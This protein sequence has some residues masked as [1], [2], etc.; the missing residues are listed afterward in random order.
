MIGAEA[1]QCPCAANAV[2]RGIEPKR[3]QQSRRRRR[4]AG[5][6]LPRLD[7]VL[8]F[9]QVEPLDIGPDHSCRMILP[10]QAIDIDGSQFDLVTHRLTQPRRSARHGLSCWRRLFRKFIKKLVVSHH[11]LRQ[12]ATLRESYLPDARYQKDSRPRRMGRAKRNPSSPY[13]ASRRSS[14]GELR[15]DLSAAAQHA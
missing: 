11:G 14:N 1:I 15:A 9:A 12:I 7:P 3:Q 10:D 8:Q 5:P 2:A 6:V 4:M 13:P